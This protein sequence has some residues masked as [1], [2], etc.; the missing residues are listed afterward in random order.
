M[1]NNSSG[2]D[3]DLQRYKAVLFKPT[4]QK[5][6]AIEGAMHATFLTRVRPVGWGDFRRF[7]ALHGLT[8][9]D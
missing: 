2:S 9:R 3:W 4:L 7:R 6:M 8:I 5:C 1:A